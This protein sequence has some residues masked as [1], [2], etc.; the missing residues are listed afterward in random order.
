MIFHQL[1]HL[2]GASLDWDSCVYHGCSERLACVCVCTSV[3]MPVLVT[4]DTHTHTRAQTRNFTRTLFHAVTEAFVRLCGGSLVRWEV[5]MLKAVLKV[6]LTLLSVVS[7]LL[8]LPRCSRTQDVT[9]PVLR[10][11]W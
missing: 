3:S 8:K 5:V 1:R 10:P 6:A 7:Y 9:E 2:V 4:S 11:Q